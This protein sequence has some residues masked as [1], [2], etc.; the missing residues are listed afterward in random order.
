LFW[1]SRFVAPPHLW[2]VGRS[3]RRAIRSITFAL[4]FI[5]RFG[6]SASIP[7]ALSAFRRHKRMKKKQRKINF[8]LA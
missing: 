5:S 1:A 8:L 3:S 2:C 4:H 6:G 7:L